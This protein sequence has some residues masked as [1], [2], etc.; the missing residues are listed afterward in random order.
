[1][2]EREKIPWENLIQQWEGETPLLLTDQVIGQ[3]VQSAKET[4]K[5]L[6]QHKEHIQ[7]L[8]LMVTEMRAQRRISGE[9]GGQDE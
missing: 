3:L 8:T 5:E 7:T 4:E 2:S 6:D 1:M 9:G